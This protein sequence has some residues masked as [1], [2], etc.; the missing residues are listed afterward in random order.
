LRAFSPYYLSGKSSRFA[1]RAVDMRGKVI[2]V[3]ETLIALG[4]NPMFYSA[5]F[6]RKLKM[7][8]FIVLS[9]AAMC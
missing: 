7:V 6:R 9:F 8:V 1:L 3:N 5:S 2:I 4:G